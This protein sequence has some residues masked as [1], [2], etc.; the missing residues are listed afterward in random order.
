MLEKCNGLTYFERMKTISQI[1]IEV[2]A[3]TEISEISELQKEV[4]SNLKKYSLV[5][6]D[7]MRGHIDEAIKRMAKRDADEM[8]VFMNALGIKPVK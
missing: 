2:D 8:K 1:C 6:L 7:Y 4:R 5:E 3:A